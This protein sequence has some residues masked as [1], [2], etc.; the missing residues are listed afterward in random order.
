VNAI[1]AL[2]M[3]GP[4]A[5]DALLALSTDESPEVRTAAAEALAAFRP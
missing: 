5:Q 1:R 4:S 2:G 3:I